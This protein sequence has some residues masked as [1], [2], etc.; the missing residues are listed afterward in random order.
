[1]ILGKILFGVG[2]K[3][4][5]FSGR[6]ICS[7]WFICLISHVEFSSFLYA[8]LIVCPRRGWFRTG[9]WSDQVSELKELA[10]CWIKYGDTWCILSYDT[11]FSNTVLEVLRAV[12]GPL[13]FGTCPFRLVLLRRRL[14][15]KNID[16]TQHN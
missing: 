2:P 6:M 15:L 10:A 14:D 12:C 7:L 5:D 9:D 4:S 13:L 16:V 1:M 8:H 11:I 3:G